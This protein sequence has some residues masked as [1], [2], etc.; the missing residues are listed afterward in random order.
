M[1]LVRLNFSIDSR[2]LIPLHIDFDII[3]IGEN[4]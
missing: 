3:V 2:L 4:I 1:S